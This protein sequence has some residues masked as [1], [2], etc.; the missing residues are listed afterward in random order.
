MEPDAPP[1]P[2]DEVKQ[3]IA[4]PA[5]TDEVVVIKKDIMAHAFFAFACAATVCRAF[6]AGVV[7]SAMPRIA[8]S[9][10][11]DYAQEGVVAAAPDYGIVPAGIMAM[12]LF[13]RVRA[14]RVLVGACALP[15]VA[16]AAAALRPSYPAL[17]AARALGGLGWGC[18]AVHFPAWVDARAP[19]KRK[20]LWLAL[21][22]V[23]LLG[24][25]LCGYAL[26]G[27]LAA[28]WTRLY[29]VEA[30]LMA[31]A[32]AAA[33]CFP[34][35]AMDV[36]RTGEGRRLLGVDTPPR[37]GL[38][39][40]RATVSTPVVARTICAGGC[41]N[42]TVGFVLYFIAQVAARE[43]P[44][45][46]PALRAAAVSAIFVAAPIPGNLA[47]AWVVER[48]IGG[49]SNL[50]P[51]LRFVAAAALGAVGCVALLPLAEPGGPWCFIAI[52]WAFLF[53]G[54]LPT[55][56]INGV[57]LAAAPRDA[58]TIASGLQFTAQN[59]MK[60]IVPLVGG[61][62]I[63][64]VGLLLGFRTVLLACAAGYAFFAFLAQRAAAGHVRRDPRPADGSPLVAPLCGDVA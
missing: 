18:A 58:G 57:V 48:R 4:P 15:A 10:H 33:A 6:E 37:S 39:K 29:L 13:E 5:P 42:G 25:I 59:L 22:N 8:A 14:R 41:M 64:R 11:L 40:L 23:C 55:P 62:V 3:S 52:C 49:Y 60:A 20:P 32:A 47:G 30:G 34:A 21:L 17:V 1:T 35:D 38:A 31:L 46:S 36:A 27:A 44:A 28:D 45:W 2:T 63:D 9:L 24:G 43:A 7:S 56:A 61:R 26:G 50:G 16:A 12:A 53:L 19:A 54:A 51:T